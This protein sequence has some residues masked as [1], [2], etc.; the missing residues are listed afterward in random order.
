[1]LDINVTLHDPIVQPFEQNQFLIGNPPESQILPQ[2]Q[3]K[4]E[5]QIL[6]EQ[7]VQKLQL[8]NVVLRP[9]ETPLKKQNK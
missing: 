8:A 7:P 4:N 2:Q 9:T 5:S 6:I 1:M 3:D